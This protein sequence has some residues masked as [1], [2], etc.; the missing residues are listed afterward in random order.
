M[1]LDTSGLLCLLYRTEPFHHLAV[2]LYANAA[3]PTT[4]NLVLAEFV[5]LVQARGLARQP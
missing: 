5:A 1:F 3:V 4:H 2:H